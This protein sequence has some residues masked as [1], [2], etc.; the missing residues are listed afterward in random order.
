MSADHS[1]FSVNK[2]KMIPSPAR[3]QRTTTSGYRNLPKPE[4]ERRWRFDTNI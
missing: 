1:G 4:S 2:G 3:N